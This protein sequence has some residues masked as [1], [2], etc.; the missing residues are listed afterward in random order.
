[1]TSTPQEPVNAAEED[2][3]GESVAGLLRTEDDLPDQQDDEVEVGLGP[4]A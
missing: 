4:D 1:M 3:D 2:P